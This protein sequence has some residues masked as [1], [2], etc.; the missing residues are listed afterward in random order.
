MRQEVIDDVIESSYAEALAQEKIRP[1]GVPSIESVESEDKESMSYIAVFEIYPE[2]KEIK[3][4]SI[5]IEKSVV[6]I[7]DD[8]LDKVIQKL[9]EQR[10]DWSG[11]VVP[12]ARATR[13]WSIS[14]AE[15]T[16]RYLK[17]GQV[18]ICS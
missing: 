3:L 17:A 9:R 2:I 4:D 13:C 12:R 8:D 11:L 16:V 15:S 6:E 10:K 1:A 5:K 18:K 14:K 7:T